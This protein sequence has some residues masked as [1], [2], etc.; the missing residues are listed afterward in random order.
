MAANV[1]W[2]SAHEQGNSFTHLISLDAAL[3]GNT[4]R[5]HDCIREDDSDGVWAHRQVAIIQTVS[6]VTIKVPS[7]QTYQ[8][9]SQ[10]HQMTGSW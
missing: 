2:Y 6:G 9:V 1:W 7:Y 4:S 10:S 3:C 5:G 8:L